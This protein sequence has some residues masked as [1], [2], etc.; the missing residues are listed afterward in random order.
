MEKIKLRAIKDLKFSRDIVKSIED[1]SLLNMETLVPRLMILYA[2]D[3]EIRAREEIENKMRYEIELKDLNKRKSI[4][5]ENISM[6]NAIIIETY[7]T[8][9]SM[10]KINEDPNYQLKQILDFT[11][12]LKAIAGIMYQSADA[13]H[14]FWS[15]VETMG[16]L[17]NIRQAQGE[18]LYDYKARVK[19]EAGAVKAKL[20]L[21][22]FKSFISKAER[23]R[24]ENDYKAQLEMEE[25]A[26]EEF[27][28]MCY[29]RRYD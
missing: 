8:D 24:Q 29:L 20:G 10:N 21:D 25:N 13:I 3:A 4:F 28:T 23:C 18:S 6:I 19:Q 9:Y 16:R 26:F 22:V 15:L 27:I 1:K 11:K 14:P 7:C 17:L 5:E 2:T 12:L